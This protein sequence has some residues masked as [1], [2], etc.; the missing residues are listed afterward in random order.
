MLICAKLVL[1]A[2]CT[3]FK[4]TGHGVPENLEHSRAC[5]WFSFYYDAASAEHIPRDSLNV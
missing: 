3:L 5:T 4:I 1:F 2:L